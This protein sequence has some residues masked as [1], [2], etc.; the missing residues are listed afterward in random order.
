MLPQ[1]SEGVAQER[2]RTWEKEL[3][4]QRLLTQIPRK[5]PAWQRWT[6]G[7]M[8]WIGAWLM[9]WGERMAQRE[10]RQGISVAG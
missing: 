4:H 6:G 2:M 3:R 10:C 8:V 7:R 1:N 5:P 9:C